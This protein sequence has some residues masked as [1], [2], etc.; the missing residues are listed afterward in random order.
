MWNPGLKTAGIICIAN[1]LFSHY[2]PHHNFY[3]TPALSEESVQTLKSM[4]TSDLSRLFRPNLLHEPLKRSSQLG[5]EQPS[6]LEI[7]KNQVSDHG[8]QQISRIYGIFREAVDNDPEFDSL[9]YLELSGVHELTRKIFR[10]NA[11]AWSSSR[12]VRIQVLTSLSKLAVESSGHYLTRDLIK[13]MITDIWSEQEIKNLQSWLKSISSY[14]EMDSTDSNQEEAI[15]RSRQ[16]CVELVDRIDP[17]HFASHVTTLLMNFALTTGS[18]LLAASII[19]RAVASNILV[20]RQAI[21]TCLMG[22]TVDNSETRQ[23]QLKAFFHVTK[24]LW[25][26]SGSIEFDFSPDLSRRIV[27]LSIKVS[28]GLYPSIAYETFQRVLK[29]ISRTSVSPPVPMRACIDLLLLHLHHESQNRA[30]YIWNYVSKNYNQLQYSMVDV[31]TLSSL[32]LR[33]SKYKRTLRYAKVLA[34]S[35]PDEAYAIDGL[36]EAL[37]IYCSRNEDMALSQK[38]YDKLSAPFSLSVLS[39]FLRLHLS[40]GDSEGAEKIIKQ[41]TAQGGKLDQSDIICISEHLS[42]T[43]GTDKA[44]EFVLKSGGKVPR[45]KA[46]GMLIKREVDR[47]NY[48]YYDQLIDGLLGSASGDVRRMAISI[49]AQRYCYGDEDQSNFARMLYQYWSLD[50]ASFK[51]SIVELNSFLDPI[52]LSRKREIFL[53]LAERYRD[54][55]IDYGEL[56]DRIRRSQK[57]D[58]AQQTEW[59][60]DL[61]SVYRSA[62]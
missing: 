37:L 1:R 14:C 32:I 57:L 30:A 60:A 40:F 7:Q 17:A 61:T 54:L 24:L 33:L 26:K 25:G 4:S 19:S 42:R 27:E 23:Y 49:T 13:Y 6:K 9:K 56:A 34:E 36:T 15:A 53:W 51:P 3:S 5:T 55:G 43:Y 12:D 59:L 44:I 16:M 22:L 62:F 50:G 11:E 18:P 10:E 41:I 8:V 38:I 39:S 2:S 45:E 20:P 35:V 21:H 29:L 52:L 46:L 47:G 58:K 48:A 28:N 31:N